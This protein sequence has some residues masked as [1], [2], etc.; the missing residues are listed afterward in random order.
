M[1]KTF[2]AFALLATPA[3]AQEQFSA[4]DALRVVGVHVNKD[5]VNHVVSVTGVKGSPQPQTWSVLVRDPGRGGVREIQVRNGKVVS[6]KP[7]SMVGSAEGATIKTSHL[8]L[9]SSGA[10]QV[11]SHTADKSGM[12][13][14]SA[15]YALRTDQHGDPVWI[16]TLH[17]VNG[18][19]VGRM[20]IGANRGNVTRT[21]GMF[22]AATMNDVATEQRVYRERPRHEEGQEQVSSQGSEEEE[23]EHGPLYGVRSRIR[24]GFHRTQEEA[25]GMFD[26]V[27]RSFSDFI[28]R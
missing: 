4:Y 27:R 22:G 26:R 8:N 7:S 21:E 2:A 18:E 23:G 10:F 12:R 13:F 28:N 16:V 20:Y 14:D 5:A 24:D 3:F 19:P 6:D 15:S 11:A 1:W 25:S 17:S 9:D